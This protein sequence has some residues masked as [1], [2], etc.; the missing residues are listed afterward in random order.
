[1]LLSIGPAWNQRL[2]A[3]WTL[4][5]LPCSVPLSALVARLAFLSPV[6]PTADPGPGATLSRLRVHPG[7]GIPSTVY[8]DSKY[9]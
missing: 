8:V 4:I 2:A 6:L 3:H 9:Y 5:S 7:D 1:M